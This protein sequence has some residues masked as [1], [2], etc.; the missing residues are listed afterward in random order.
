MNRRHFLG[1][2]L[3][4]A[5][6]AAL[7]TGAAAF[8]A[9]TSVT[10]SVTGF[11]GDGREVTLEIAALEELKGALRGNLLLPGGEGYDVARRVLNPSIDK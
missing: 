9:L 11:T 7:P 1:G 6:A 8:K 2:S 10:S 5:M 4:A 3:S